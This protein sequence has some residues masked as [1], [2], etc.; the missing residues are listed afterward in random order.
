MLYELAKHARRNRAPENFLIPTHSEGK[1]SS[2]AL[3]RTCSLSHPHPARPP[4]SLGQPP[5]PRLGC[6]SPSGASGRDGPSAARSPGPGVAAAVPFP[7]AAGQGSAEL[8]CGLRG[9]SAGRRAAAGSERGSLLPSAR[10]RTALPLPSPPGEP[11]AEGSRRLPGSPGRRKPQGREQPGW[12]DAAPGGAARYPQASPAPSRPCGD[13]RG[14]RRPEG[15][16]PASAR[17]P[18]QARGCAPA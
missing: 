10:P 9:R 16:G 3:R 1:P 18:R 4:A 14:C 12:R 17:P 5:Q 7:G 2:A 11:R 15:R 8:T 13:G 6:P